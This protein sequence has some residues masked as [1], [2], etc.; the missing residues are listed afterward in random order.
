MRLEELVTTMARQAG[1]EADFDAA[2]LKALGLSLE[3][4]RNFKATALPL[5]GALQRIFDGKKIGWR[6]EDRKL[7]IGLEPKQPPRDAAAP[8]NSAGV[9]GL[10]GK[11]VEGRLIWKGGPAPGVTVQVFQSGRK[12]PET[13]VTDMDGRFRVPAAWWEADQHHFLVAANDDRVGWFD[14]E[15]HRGTPAGGQRS[16]DGSITITLL[17]R[18][19]KVRGRVVDEEGKPLKD[20]RMAVLSMFH[21]E[22]LST[23]PLLH[24]V[25]NEKAIAPEAIT[26]DAGRFELALPEGATAALSLRHPGR[27][28]VRIWVSRNAT[29]LK[30]AVAPRGGRIAGRVV[31]GRTGGPLAGIS[32]RAEAQDLVSIKTGDS[33]GHLGYD[34]TDADGRYAIDGLVVGEFNVLFGASPIQKS[35]GE[36]LIAPAKE[37]A[38]VEAGKTLALDFSAI[39]GRRLTGRVLE[40]GTNR[41]LPNIGVGYNGPARPKSGAAFLYTK[42]DGEGRFELRVPPG[43]SRVYVAGNSEKVSRCSAELT[44][45]SDH[46]PDPIELKVDLLAGPPPTPKNTADGRR[47]R[48]DGR[49]ANQ[50]PPRDATELLKRW[51]ERDRLLDGRP[52]VVDQ[53][54]S[55]SISPRSRLES[56]RHNA[57]RFGFKVPD[58]PPDIPADYVQ[59]RRVRHTVVLRGD[60]AIMVN[61]GEQEP[62]LHPPYVDSQAGRR[63]SS[64]GGEQRSLNV[65]LSDMYLGAAP[66]RGDFFHLELWRLLWPCGV[67][68][69]KYVESI[70]DTV[71]RGDLLEVSGTM[72]LRG[73]YAPDDP[74]KGKDRFV[75]LLD[76][77]LVARKAVIHFGRNKRFEIDVR[78]TT[79]F[80]G[81]PPIGSES[82]FHEIDVAAG[83]PETTLRRFTARTLTVHPPLPAET[84]RKYALLDPPAGT[85]VRDF[86]P[87]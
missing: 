85:N 64:F 38:Q 68:F 57:R 2:V 25:G 76:G 61:E 74:A 4:R 14:F 82:S 53:S 73:S 8:L 9:Q 79:E 26:D 75:I 43:P 48:V 84:W 20:A 52:I 54:W 63:N 10:P 29:D 46:D 77:D 1:L 86:R 62:I 17:P 69:A 36:G 7:L 50:P 19:H 33:S 35:D 47:E 5:E 22:N 60:E 42:S 18:T 49:E 31:D 44:V 66:Q 71:A 55:E 59:A 80:A 81:D 67:G 3:E 58:L 51:R 78:R 37:G 65:A 72:G 27:V 11:T 13:L 28:N 83:R 12:L 23:P 32:I 30:D 39:P 21:P 41:P 70:D 45:P 87:R 24:R 15:R 56:E 16:A 6:V 40:K 34:L